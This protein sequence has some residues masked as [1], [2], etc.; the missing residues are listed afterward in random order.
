[1]R[2]LLFAAMAVVMVM[3]ISRTGHSSTTAMQFLKICESPIREESS[4]CD[5]FLAGFNA[6]V[7]TT[8]QLSKYNM[9]NC[10]PENFSSEQL[11]RMF[12]KSTKEKPEKLHYNM[13]DFLLKETLRSYIHHK[14][15]NCSD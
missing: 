12:I 4:L 14:T 7:Y 1:M 8:N 3:G 15:S 11:K 5:S 13:V 2:K 6:G 9:E 10:L